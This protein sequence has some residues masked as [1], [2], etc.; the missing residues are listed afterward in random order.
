MA[1]LLHR[2][3][4]SSHGRYMGRV[5]L[6]D[7]AEFRWRAVPLHRRATE[8]IRL[9]ISASVHTRIYVYAQDVT[10]INASSLRDW[11]VLT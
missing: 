2:A 3:Q 7:R 6:R 5:F 9:F 4:L 8:R 1:A 11:K 10:R